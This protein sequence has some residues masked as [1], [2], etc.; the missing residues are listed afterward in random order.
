MLL[1]KARVAASSAGFWAYGY[2]LQYVS[3]PCYMTLWPDNEG[4]SHHREVLNQAE[5]AVLGYGSRLVPSLRTI[6]Y[7]LS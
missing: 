5:L 7:S 1:E 6:Q 4:D 3:F 2:M